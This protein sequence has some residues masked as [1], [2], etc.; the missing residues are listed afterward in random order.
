M[1]TNWVNTLDNITPYTCPAV[2]TCLGGNL[3]NPFPQGFT[4]PPGSANGLYTG[5]G[6]LMEGVMQ[7]SPTPYALEWGLDVQEQLPWGMTADAAYAANRGKQMITSG[8]GGMDWDQ[9]PSEYLSM[10]SALNAQVAN[11]FYG[12]PHVTGTL[13]APT[14]SKEQLLI[15]YPQYLEMWPLR[16]EGGD[17]QYDG[18]QLTLNKRLSSA[19]TDSGF[20]CLVK[21][22][23]QQ[24]NPSRHIPSHGRL[25][26]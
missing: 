15:K 16:F 25:R 9:L 24:H 11:P 13:S 6:S 2:G 22:L 20:V 4:T 21:D 23:R 12:D 17:S 5:A 18:L 1:Q 26:S 3:D 19:I 7:Q 14:V 10:G 8:E